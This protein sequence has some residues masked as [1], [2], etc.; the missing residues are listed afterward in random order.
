MQDSGC[1]ALSSDGTPSR[2]GVAATPTAFRYRRRGHRCQ[3]NPRDAN[4]GTLEL[5]KCPLPLHHFLKLAEAQ[6]I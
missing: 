3:F 1:D 6:T 4:F 2:P 5:S